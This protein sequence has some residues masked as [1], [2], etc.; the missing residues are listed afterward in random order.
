MEYLDMREHGVSHSSI[1]RKT[2]FVPAAPMLHPRLFGAANVTAQ[3][4]NL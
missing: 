1:A 2:A 4:G 3:C